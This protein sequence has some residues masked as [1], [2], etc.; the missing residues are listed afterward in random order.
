MGRKK[1]YFTDEERRVA[2]KLSARKYRMKNPEK[3]AINTAKWKDKNTQY[4][5]EYQ[6][7]YHERMM[8]DDNYKKSR[9][10]AAINYRKRK[11]EES[12]KK[13]IT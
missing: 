2:Q 6:H 5:I 11:K 9:R 13:D 12:N 7:E 10:I 1:I 4:V 8:Q 3:M